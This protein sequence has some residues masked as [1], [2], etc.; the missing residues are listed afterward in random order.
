MLGV[1]AFAYAVRCYDVFGFTLIL[2]YCVVLH[3]VEL[4]LRC[5][6][7]WVAPIAEC[8]VLTCYDWVLCAL[9]DMHRCVIVV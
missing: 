6:V 4:A 7:Y 1:C 8:S 2:T 9:C 5:V 3:N